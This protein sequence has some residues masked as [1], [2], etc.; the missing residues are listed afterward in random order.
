ML[1]IVEVV[2]SSYVRTKR[3]VR[4]GDLVG[5]RWRTVKILGVIVDAG[6]P[7]LYYLD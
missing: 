6:F 5:R 7:R 4:H 2:D 1:W 3:R